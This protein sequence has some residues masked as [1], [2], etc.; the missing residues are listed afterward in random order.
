[1][2][3]LIVETVVP[4]E[5]GPLFGT[6]GVVWIRERVVEEIEFAVGETRDSLSRPFLPLQGA[7]V[8]QPL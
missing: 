1:M 8:F 4:V 7:N 3:S 5:G 2:S 6:E